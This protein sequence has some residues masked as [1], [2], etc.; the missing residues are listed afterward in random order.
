MKILLIGEYSNF[1]NSLK[2]GLESL[3]HS[4]VLAGRK[5]GFKSFPVDIS[6]EPKIT[7]KKP[8]KHL[9]NMIY[10]VIGFDI[11]SLEIVYLFL[12]NKNYMKGYDLVQLINEYPFKSTP[13]FDKLLLKNIFKHNKKTFV[14]A[15]GNDT[16]YINFLLNSSLDYHILTPY[17][18]NSN[19][20]KHFKYSLD[21]LNKSHKKLNEF[22]LKKSEFYIPA[23][24]DYYMAYKNHPKS[25]GL[26]PFP[27]NID[28]FAYLPLNYNTKIKIFHGINRVNYLKKGNNFFHEA[29][30]RIDTKYGDQI[31]IIEVE[32]IKYSKYINLYNECH[33]LLDQVYSY[34]QGYNAL[35]AMAKGKVVF[36]GVSQEFLNHYNINTPIAINAL[37]DTDYLVNKLSHLIDNPNKIRKISKNARQYIID[38]HDYKSIAQKYIEVWDI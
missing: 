25:K 6:F 21:Y 37:P 26:I 32:N 33:I 19:L 38:F 13:Y 16:I 30:K 11:A 3:G 9:R 4:V 10:K 23:D 18:K 22:V 2:Q 5:D 8:L 34:D 29:L 31:E 36:T 14:S 24:M 17:L 35:E 20:K 15:C 7:S 28:L 1:H 12:K 27:I